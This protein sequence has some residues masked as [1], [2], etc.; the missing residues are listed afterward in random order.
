M[1]KNKEKIMVCYGLS[2]L[3]NYLKSNPNKKICLYLAE[4]TMY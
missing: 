4:K 1:G 2:D 3:R